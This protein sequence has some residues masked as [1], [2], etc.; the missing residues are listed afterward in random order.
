M[1]SFLRGC[2]QVYQAVVAAL[3]QMVNTKT[4]KEILGYGIDSLLVVKF[5]CQCEYSSMSYR[6][7]LILRAPYGIEI[8]HNIQYSVPR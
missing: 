7:N 5:R 8:S 6:S 2:Q 1:I 4:A 3:E